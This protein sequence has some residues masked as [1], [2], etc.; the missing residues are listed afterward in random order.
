VAVLV[1]RGTNVALSRHLA[2]RALDAAWLRTQ[3]PN[4][5]TN[6]QNNVRLGAGAVLRQQEAPTALRRSRDLTLADQKQPNRPE[7]K[8]ANK[9][10]YPVNLN[11][12]NLFE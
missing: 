11:G 7:E 6:A 5:T 4:A 3:L 12:A 9:L 8:L 10:V 2:V 1:G